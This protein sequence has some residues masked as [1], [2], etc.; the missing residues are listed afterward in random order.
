[1]SDDEKKEERKGQSRFKYACVCASNVNRSMAAHQVLQRNNFQVWSY[2]T[3]SQIKMPGPTED[4]SYD[5]GTTYK[6]ILDYMIEQGD[7]FYKRMGLIEMIDRDRQIKEKPERFAEVF[8]GTI[9]FD[10]IFTYQRPVM[11]RVVREFHSNANALKK[12]VLCIII[13]I[14][15]PDDHAHALESAKITLELA[16]QIERLPNIIEEIEDELNRVVEEKK[17]WDL[18]FHIISY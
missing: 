15:T 12:F 10:V 7:D 14:E 6:E 2:G 9:W 16:R 18:T 17:G 8:E 5:F 13:N 4:V 1:M 3:N 11:E